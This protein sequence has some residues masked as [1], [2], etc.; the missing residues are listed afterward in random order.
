MYGYC[1]CGCSPMLSAARYPARG[2][3]LRWLEEYQRDLEQRVADV[4]DEVKRL[5]DET[6]A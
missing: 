4:A 6:G 1:G 3:R 5:K 2:E